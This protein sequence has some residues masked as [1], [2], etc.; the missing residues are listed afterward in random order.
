[1]MQSCYVNFEKSKLTLGFTALGFRREFSV[2]NEIN[3]Y[4]A[5]QHGLPLSGPTLVMNTLVGANLSHDIYLFDYASQ[6]MTHT[7]LIY[8]DGDLVH[9]ATP[10]KDMGRIL[11][12]GDL[13][14]ELHQKYAS[15]GLDEKIRNVL[16]EIQSRFYN[17]ADSQ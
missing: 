13:F 4:I 5:W 3:G 10:D 11:I 2:G 1:M 16:K 8:E 17:T 9:I 12:H 7:Q 15:S 14:C 6:V